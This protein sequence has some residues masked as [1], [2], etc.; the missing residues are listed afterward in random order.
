MPVMG[1]VTGDHVAKG[2]TEVV[3]I[4]ATQRGGADDVVREVDGLVGAADV[5]LAADRQLQFAVPARAV[6]V[7]T[8][9]SSHKMT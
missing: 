1:H 3:R 2:V 6:L 4:T 5:V 7:G 9:K 8:G